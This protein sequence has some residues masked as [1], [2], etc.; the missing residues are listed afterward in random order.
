M[1]KEKISIKV[2]ATIAN[3]VC[4]FD[5]LGMAVKEPFDE[6]TVSI[7]AVPG[8]RIEHLDDFGLPAEAGKNVAGVALEALLNAME[9]RCAATG[10]QV[11]G[12][13]ITITKRIMPGSGLGSSAASSMGAVAAANALLNN[14]FSYSDLVRFA[15]EGE[16]LAGGV[17]HADNVAPCLYGGVTV[18]NS[19]KPPQVT[20][21][22]APP[23][24][25][26]IVHPQIEVKTSDSRRIIKKDVPLKT[27]IE[28]WSNIAGLVAGF[29]TEN[30]KLIGDSLR[31]VI[32]EPVRSMLIPG[33]EEVKE[34]SLKAGALGGGISGSG[35]SIF[36]LCEQE[37][38]AR[39]VE[40]EM[41]FVYDTM[42]LPYKT[43]VTTIKNSPLL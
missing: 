27:A 34:Q 20:A 35:P 29:C 32:F 26:A 17:A 1:L 4:G 19:A 9:S 36:M 25:V 3:I 11:P 30:Y 14:V 10:Q 41:K 5:V 21:I 28:Q 8:I 6:M 15:M 7:S 38:V 37:R 31:D 16:K 40:K 39:Q 12:F 13:D 42:G 22:P 33:F 24:W 18:L 2:P 43:Y 23:L